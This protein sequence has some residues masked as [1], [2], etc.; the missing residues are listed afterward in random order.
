MFAATLLSFTVILKTLKIVFQ[1]VRCFKPQILVV[2][3]YGLEYRKKLW[4][5]F[6]LR[7]NSYFHKAAEIKCCRRVRFWLARSFG[8]ICP[9]HNILHKIIH[10]EILSIWSE[11]L[12]LG[13]YAEVKT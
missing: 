2:F 11:G 6:M 4:V 9:V 8:E 7:T 13:G 10:Q 12:G 5:F 3:F 1:N